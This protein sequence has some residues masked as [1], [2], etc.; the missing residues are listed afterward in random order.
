MKNCG[1]GLTGR[2][3]GAARGADRGFTVVELII[4]MFIVGIVA[5]AIFTLYNSFYSATR[6]QDLL[7]E[8]QQNARVGI[9]LM[10]RELVN[11]GYDA[12][13][14]DI[15]T[16]ATANSVEFTYTD[17]SDN[18]TVSPTAGQR[19]KV[20]Y[21]LSTEAGIQYLQRTEKVMPD[22]TPAT[23][24]VIPYVDQSGGLT[25]T[26][27]DVDG[28]LIDYTSI[29]D[30]GEQSNRN[31]IKF[32][33]VSLKTT[34]KA[35]VQGTSEVKTFTLDTHVMLRNI[36]VGATSADTTAPAAPT[37]VQVRDPGICARLKVK[38]TKNS[39]GDIAGYRIYYGSATGTYTGILNVPTTVLTGSTYSCT[40]V[41]S[42]IECT[43]FPTSPSL[44]YTP[45]DPSGGSGATYFI[46]VKAYD[47]SY[48]YSE[49]SSEVSGSPATSNATFDTG[50][51]D[52]TL[53]P[54]KPA[55]VTGLSAVDGA[56]D[57]QVA[58]SWSAYNT[59]NNPD[60]VGFRIYRS[61][62]PFTAYPVDPASA[63]IDW[64][65]GEPGSGKPE[66]SQTS[67]AYTDV[68][69]SLA[70]CTVY[71]YAIA[72]VN[73]DATLISDSG[74]DPDSEKYLQTNYAA[75]CGNG[76]T[77]CTPGTGFS[78]VSGSDTAPNETTAPDAPVIDARA[79]WKRV[80]LS[81]TQPASTDLDQ[82]CFYEND[83]A[84]YPA[85]LTDTGSYP[86]VSNCYQ[87]NTGSTPNARLVP[88]SGGIF[89]SSEL[90]PG[91][92]TSF[93]HDSMTVEDPG[94]PSLAETGT[95]S[96][97]AVSFDLCGNGSPYTSAQA[98]TILCGED[99]ASGEK[100]PAVTAVSASCCSNPVS[101]T[102]TGVPSDT[103]S[104]STPTN[105]YDLAG[106]R[107][108]RSTSVDFTGST[109]V[110]GAAPYWGSTYSDTS[111]SDGGT[112]YYRIVS[113]DCP[114]ERNNPSEATIKS[115]MLSGYLNSVTVGP[116]T[117]GQIDRDEKCEDPVAP[118][119]NSCTKD[120]HREAL[121][122]V[123]VNNST[124][125]GNSTTT[126]KSEYTH[127]TVTMYLSNTAAGAMTIQNI[128]VS[129]VNSGA[130]LREIKIGGGRS[131]ITA[132]DTNIA[133]GATATVTGNDPYTR[134]V[135]DATI[136][137]GTITAGARYVP[138]T[139]KFKDASDSAVDMRDDQLLITIKARN[140]S[141][142]TTQCL[143]YMTVSRG[144]EG[145][146]VPFGPSISATQQDKPASPTFSYA[147]PG[148]SGSN[149]V[150]SGSVAPIEAP[151]SV[152]VTVSASI[153]GNTTNQAT[154]LKVAVSSATLYYK[155]TANTVTT[156]PTSGYTSVSMTNA[157]GNTWTGAIPANDGFR[158]WY[159][160]VAKD[161]D[162]N[163]D[164]D[165]E[166]T[167]GAYVY[168]Q[169]EF[170]VCLV[171]PNAPTSLQ[172]SPSG[173]DVAL[174][175]TAPTTYTNGATIDTGLDPIQYRIYRGGTQI[176][177][178]QAGTTY[179]DT[180]LA[181]GVYGYYV[182]AINS[183][184]DPSPNVSAESNT[185]SACVG[186]TGQATI[187]VTP[188]S[189]YRGESYTV[190]IVDCLA[191]NGAYSATTEVINTSSGF[192]GFTNTSTAPGSYNPTITETG[193]ATGTFTKT[194]TTTSDV[195]DS[196][197]L[198]TL[199]TDTVTVTYPYASPSSRTV[200]VVV[201]PCTNTPKA[202]TGF[203]GTIVS[204]NANLSWTAV[205]Q[206]TDNSAITDLVGY[207]IYERVCAK[208][209]TNCTGSDIVA[210]W[211]LRT[212]V[213]AGTT[214]ASLGP[215]QGAWNQR[216]YYFK[217][218]A[219]DSCSTPVES[220]YSSTWNETN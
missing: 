33:S 112:Y 44:T 165:P 105:P 135:T 88:D 213:A 38:W 218:T 201:D 82:T 1:K 31:G 157:S 110:S 166:K 103:G 81:L 99:P 172:A 25:L 113:T 131:G 39:E 77:A 151:S 127:E 149:T 108:F 187:T 42:T 199:A 32:I 67:T 101:L 57:G 116:V 69:P 185:A 136:T 156:A 168:D 2:R 120:D 158:L 49:Y 163:W 102:W 202:P 65:A 23:E 24:K 29:D 206:N 62:A 54:V 83:S 155:A 130:Y 87:V 169:G 219:Y 209:K 178:D 152:T 182:K 191:I 15:L 124:G 138:I 111:V 52:S 14:A 78:A 137:T 207:K 97:R 6:S 145:V 11:A 220:A 7:L 159:Y 4:S 12:G 210:E 179:S 46:A 16:E 107:V 48:N 139:F 125:T 181:N 47:N 212:T 37:G 9:D 208:N 20:K 164:R 104:P 64:I 114:Y 123:D 170:D 43:I 180:G 21:S 53:N 86:K 154:G 118:T 215:D 100:P 217:A 56:T 55:V 205:T 153:Q 59:T 184:A 134:A 10:E 142:S 94:T 60:V 167:E 115:D 45:S 91:Q 40:T 92:S 160:I 68:G 22:G 5:A 193:P 129:W 140:D 197:K 35:A 162:G 73:C 51:D 66:I 203:T 84:T 176:G 121:T 141:T 30:A 41:S 190:T 132:I 34:A 214:T 126:P 175:W 198:L 50:S 93:W 188:T 28:A 117:P 8:A 36:G 192:T 58:L 119:D 109:M 150:P 216:I 95:Y 80:A 3:T 74:G 61:T 19:L 26:Y 71:Y 144:L 183:C 70:G 146:S 72:P 173:S 147:V 204:N 18:T 13:T 98:T 17:P 189:I 161:A 90:A 63:G 196:T 171:T 195:T 27:Y 76:S 122:G 186:A 128:S 89:T 75:T 148:S 79:G 174:V 143:S 194:I 211:F 133:A 200:S 177:S 85:L 96:Y 106:Y